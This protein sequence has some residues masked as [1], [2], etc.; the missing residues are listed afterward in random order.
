[1]GN[2]QDKVNRVLR[3]LNPPT[4]HSAVSAALFQYAT[5]RS[6]IEDAVAVQQSLSVFDQ[7]YITAHAALSGT[8]DRVISEGDFDD[9]ITDLRAG[10]FY[11]RQLRREDEVNVVDAGTSSLFFFKKHVSEFIFAE[12]DDGFVVL[13]REPDAGTEAAAAAAGAASEQQ[14]LAA[15]VASLSQPQQ[16]QAAAAAAGALASFDVP[17]DSVPGPV[18]AAMAAPPGPAAAGTPPQ[19]L[20]AL[21]R[22]YA[23]KRRKWRLLAQRCVRTASASCGWC[24]RWT[25]RGRWARLLRAVTGDGRDATRRTRAAA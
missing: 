17:L 16:Q 22:Q 6:G 3:H 25:A 13:S 11:L 21:V 19:A 14:P 23:A 8:L 5:L 18:V 20:D 12:D 7:A 15:S 24:W 1:M 4:R 2:A 9:Y 10:V